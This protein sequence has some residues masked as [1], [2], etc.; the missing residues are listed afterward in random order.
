M[1]QLAPT[2][3]RAC[4]C[5]EPAR[6][7]DVYERTPSAIDV[8]VDHLG[9]DAEAAL[10][11]L[12]AILEG[13]YYIAPRIPTDPM[14]SAYFWAYG[15][16]GWNPR[17]IIQNIGKARIRWQAMGLAGSAMALSRKFSKLKEQQH[18]AK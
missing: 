6:T 16:Q 15:H 13:G 12:R 11:L 17:T 8:V 10:E 4:G 9:C 18:D 3:T 1:E 5:F 2:E 7:A 14:L